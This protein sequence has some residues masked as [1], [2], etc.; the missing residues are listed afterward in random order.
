MA[1]EALASLA[2]SC[3]V[4]VEGETK[5]AASRGNFSS[6][7]GNP[8]HAPPAQFTAKLVDQWW[9]A[10]QAEVKEAFLAGL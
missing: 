3:K 2:K 10:N 1:N 6:G 9:G 7:K 4:Y 5:K 8:D